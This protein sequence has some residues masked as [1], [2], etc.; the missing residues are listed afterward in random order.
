M[1]RLK[2]FEGRQP[3]W[4]DDIDFLQDC[5]AGE[6]ARL[7]EGLVPVDSIP[8]VVILKGCEPQL[9]STTRTFTSGIIYC[10]GE[11]L[12]VSAS[13][14]PY[15]KRPVLKVYEEVDESGDR[16]LEDT[17]ENVS[18]Y[19]KR[20]AVIKAAM[21]GSSNELNFSKA[22]RLSTLFEQKYGEAEEVLYDAQVESGGCIS[23]FRLVKQG[24]TLTLVGNFSGLE[25]D[26]EIEVV[27]EYA[28]RHLG[29]SQDPGYHWNVGISYGV[30]ALHIKN[31]AGTWKY[32]VA[33]VCVYAEPAQDYSSTKLNIRAFCLGTTSSNF[34]NGNVECQGGFSI[35]L[36]TI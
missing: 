9:I 18:C 2:T 14:I 1:D 31:D 10:K 30:A 3:F 12:R 4:L 13:S 25:L 21:T 28:A 8:D 6:I 19:I 29:D 22:V 20:S 35:T 15:N 33:P 23:H 16:L 11:L 24:G 32:Q 36:N 26:S 5:F 17:E 7:V 34:S 27:S